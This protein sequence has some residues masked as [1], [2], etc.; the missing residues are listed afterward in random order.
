MF[1]VAETAFD[2]VVFGVFALGVL[3]L[4]A[5]PVLCAL[6]GGRRPPPGSP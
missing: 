3:A 1:A 2:W 4:L 6:S 5:V